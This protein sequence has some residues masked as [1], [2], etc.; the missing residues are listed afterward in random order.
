MEQV[1]FRLPT[2]EKK[3]L[4]ARAALLGLSIQEHLTNL[5]HLDK[6]KNLV[7]LELQAI[8]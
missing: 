2:Q 5:V 3:E 8:K 6:E 4:K 1:L 7:K